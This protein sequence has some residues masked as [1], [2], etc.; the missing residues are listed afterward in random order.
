MTGR[1]P[2]VLYPIRKLIGHCI[3]S[4]NLQGNGDIVAVSPSCRAILHSTLSVAATVCRHWHLLSVCVLRTFPALVLTL[5]AIFCAQCQRQCD[6]YLR[7]C[8]PKIDRRYDTRLRR[9]VSPLWMYY[10]LGTWNLAANIIA[11]SGLNYKHQI[12]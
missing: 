3:V 5:A 1:D 2:W 8:L 6:G 12:R 11:R 4:S 9:A 10:L 7:N